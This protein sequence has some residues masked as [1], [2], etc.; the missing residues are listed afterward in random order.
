MHIKVLDETVVTQEK[1]K[2]CQN[3]KKGIERA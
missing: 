3:K 2:K 1:E